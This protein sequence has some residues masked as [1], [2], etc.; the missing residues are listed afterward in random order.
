VKGKY[1]KD[2]SWEKADHFLLENGCEVSISLSLYGEMINRIDFP[3]GTYWHCSDGRNDLLPEWA[4]PW[5]EKYLPQ[6]DNMLLRPKF[7]RIYP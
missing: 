6:M 3:D 7:E 4:K 2:K 1:L 5:L